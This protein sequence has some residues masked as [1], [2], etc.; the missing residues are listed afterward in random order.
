[1]AHKGWRMGLVA[2][3]ASAAAVLAPAATGGH[4]VPPAAAAGDTITGTVTAQSNGAPLAGIRVQLFDAQYGSDI[5]V[6]AT[7]TDSN[8]EYTL[9]GPHLCGTVFVQD[10]AGVLA[11]RSTP[12]CGSGTANL[13]MAPG[14]TLTVTVTADDTGEPIEGSCVYT[15]L[16][17]ADGDSGPTP[18]AC[19]DAAGHAVFGL[20]PGYYR[21]EAVSPDGSSFIGGRFDHMGLY[22]DGTPVPV[23]PARSVSIAIGLARGHHITGTVVADDTGLPLAGA[24]VTVSDGTS[25]PGT[26]SA[27]TTDALGH[28]VTTGLIDGDYNV[29]FNAYDGTYTTGVDTV[30]VTIVGS[31]VGGVEGR[32]A[33]GVTVEGTVTNSSGD[34]IAGV[35]LGNGTDSPDCHYTDVNGHYRWGGWQQEYGAYLTIYHDGYA[36]YSGP[37]EL[38]LAVNTHDITL[39]TLGHVSGHVTVAAGGAP[40]TSGRVAAISASY[41]DPYPSTWADVGPDGSFEFTNLYAADFAFQYLGEPDSLLADEFYGGAA[42]FE[43]ATVVTVDLESTTTGV[44]IALDPGGTLSGTVTDP[45]GAPLPGATVTAAGAFTGEHSATTASDGTYTIHGMQSGAVTVR[46]DGPVVTPG[47]QPEFYDEASYDTPIEVGVTIGQPTNGIDADLQ[48]LA[49]I[50]G[51]L[52]DDATDA[53]MPFSITALQP[54][55]GRGLSSTFGGD[56]GA[57]AYVF[58]VAPGTYVLHAAPAI[59]RSLYHDTAS[60]FAD[61]TPVT[62]VAGQTLPGID[63]RVEQP[64]GPTFTPLASPQ[65]LVDSRAGKLG[66]L[67]QPTG[68]L[69]SDLATRMVPMVPQRFVVSDVGGLPLAA[70]GIALNVTAVNPS[71]KGYLTMYPC[72]ST[73]TDVPATSTLNFGAGVTIANSTTLQPDAGGVCIVASKA[74]D[75]ILDATGSLDDRFVALPTPQRLLD[76]REGQTGLIETPAGSLGGDFVFHFGVDTFYSFD[77]DGIGGAPE[78]YYKALNVV[79]VNPAAKGFLTV[80]PCD[81]G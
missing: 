18:N 55:T 72:A 58:D 75:V 50:T 1:M 11:Y 35:C 5:L 61:A 20:V 60:E 24:S 57:N 44:D 66:L 74:T 52:V 63:F 73:A 26:S 70:E 68:S 69:G 65:R 31:D 64:S 17:D 56:L 49:R 14:G 67:E 23:G 51:T 77:I 54:T 4:A 21:T 12:Q 81:Y 42:D 34:P 22:A 76:T 15:A 43:S 45:T 13:T 19:T 36:G 29:Y 41:A 46:F 40:V 10:P 59:G 9:S 6:T 25:R 62:V 47:Y 39:Q 33:L 53:P 30:P 27:A 3:L 28:F 78:G 32:M 7:T 48:R 80:Y 38:P 2:V 16:F 79:A 8:G 71:A 37:V